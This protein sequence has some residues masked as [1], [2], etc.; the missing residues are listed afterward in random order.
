MVRAMIFHLAMAAAASAAHESENEDIILQ[1]VLQND[2]LPERLLIFVPGAGVPTGNYVATAQAIQQAS[3]ELRLTVV[4]PSVFQKICIIQCLSSSTCGL[5]K[6]RVEAAAKKANFKGTNPKED[7]FMAG[8][9]MGSVCANNLVK[10]YAYEYAGLMEFGGYVDK[11]GE[12]SVASYPIPVL[13]LNGEL[14]GGGARPGK[15]SLFYKQFKE[16]ADAHGEEQALTLK[17]VHVLPGVDHS[18]FCPGF[19]VTAI[20]DLKSEVSQEEALQAIASGAGAFLHLNSP[21]S[22]SAKAEAMQTMKSLLGFTAEMCEPY[23]RAF[24]MEASGSLCE[25]AQ[26]VVAGLSAEDAVRL[27][28]SVNPVPF[29]DFKDG[30]TGYGPGSGDDLEVQIV[31]AFEEASGFGPA[32]N[33]GASKSVDCKMLDA[34]RIAEQMHVHTE[35]GRECGELTKQA[36]AVAEQLLPQRSMERYRA[37][38]RSVC[39]VADKGFATTGAIETTE[40]EA[41]LEVAALALV[42]D[43][44]SSNSPGVHYCKLLSPSLALE[45]MMTDGIK[46][47]PYDLTGSTEDALEHVIV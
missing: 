1:P 44:N 14:D 3:T 2:S 31:S 26:R 5:L 20:K 47:F 21:V 35:T 45:W 15:M 38:G 33:H 36:V 39:T 7:T 24:E 27:K 32:D 11:K 12:S 13:L 17:P 23:L 9:S 41:C 42:N 37:K 30:R 25:D 29:S 6:H 43:V 34:T 16:Y 8:H 4:I 19:F 18:D 22:Q 40:T 46:P 10:G 28:V